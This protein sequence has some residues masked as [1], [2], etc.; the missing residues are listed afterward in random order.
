MKTKLV[1]S[2]PAGRRQWSFLTVVAVVAMVMG[3]GAKGYC[4]QEL[5]AMA[6]VSADKMNIL[7]AGVPNPVTVSSSVPAENLY[8]D[9]G[10]CTSNALGEG[11]Y[12]VSVPLELVDQTVKIVVST[13]MEDGTVLPIREMDF[14]VRQVPNPDVCIGAGIDGGTYSRDVILANPLIV[15]QTPKDF[16]YELLWKVMSY[17]I[18]FYKGDVEEAPIMVK[19]PRFP[20]NIVRKIQNAPKGTIM[21]ISEI[22]VQSPAGQRTLREF[23]V[24]IK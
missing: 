12:E 8:I 9:W 6:A 20:E 2:E 16:D 13:V 17:K 1:K 23:T 3:I 21:E 14:R 10:G 11:R 24:T 5:T 15:A 7:Y 4:Q 19:G 22:R 18:T